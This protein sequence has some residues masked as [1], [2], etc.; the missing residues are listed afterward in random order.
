MQIS[1]TDAALP[2]EEGDEI[3]I[4]KQGNRYYAC[5]REAEINGQQDGEG[6]CPVLAAADLVL[7]PWKG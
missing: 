2:E 4:W 5:F 3:S 7:Q 1:I 6:D